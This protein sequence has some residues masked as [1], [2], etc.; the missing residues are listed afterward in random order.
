MPPS[1]PRKG[2]IVLYHF[3]NWKPNLGAGGQFEPD[4][5]RCRPALVVDAAPDGTIECAVFLSITDN[6]AAPG[7]MSVGPTNCVKV[8]PHPH[9][10]HGHLITAAPPSAHCWSWQE[11]GC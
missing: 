9:S 5:I 10:H 8:P 1:Y 4:S 6:P 2:D 11:P 7:R 3:Q